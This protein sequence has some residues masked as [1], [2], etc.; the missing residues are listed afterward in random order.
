MVIGPDVVVVELTVLGFVEETSGMSGI[1]PVASP[2][3]EPLISPAMWTRPVGPRSI[4]ETLIVPT[5]P[6]ML[7]WARG[8]IVPIANVLT[9]LFRGVMRP[10]SS[11][12]AAARPPS[13]PDR[14]RRLLI[15]RQL[16]GA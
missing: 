3:W 16:A 6:L 2:P 5:L 7:T 8:P 9:E 4:S 12:G 14:I 13:A 10:S 11:A 15:A 1:S